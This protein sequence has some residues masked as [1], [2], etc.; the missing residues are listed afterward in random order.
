MGLL[1]AAIAVAVYALYQ[2]GGI[3]G[4]ASS[5]PGI[6]PTVNTAPTGV[7]VPDN[8]VGANNAGIFAAVQANNVALNAIPIAGPAIAAVANALTSSLQAASAKRAA[9]AK[10]ENQAVAA[11][12]P[13]WDAAVT[14]IVAAYNNGG[15]SAA[16]VTSLLAS[17]M[18]N[19]WS[20][21]TPQIQP[22][23]N[24]C[25]GGATVPKFPIAINYCSGSIGAACC[26]GFAD[27]Q[28]GVNNMNYAVGITDN[29]GK[30][31]PAVIPQVF[32]SKYG[33]IARAAYTVTFTRP[34]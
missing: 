16:Q 25:N 11:A 24:G 6:A 17:I 9:Q 8:A 30:S 15:L 3:P 19:Y 33:G 27:L 21:V 5:L 4:V 13:G 22:G 7:I 26:V 34:S 2:S 28:T 10:T 20:E 14:Q 18:A 23:R 29:T 31:T 12:V 32:G 1:L